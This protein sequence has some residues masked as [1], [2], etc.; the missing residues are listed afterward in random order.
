MAW[1]S[2]NVTEEETEAG[3]DS[4]YDL[5][6]DPLLADSLYFRDLKLGLSSYFKQAWH[7]KPRL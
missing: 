4:C 5:P 1:K 3:C 7:V 2:G 6:D